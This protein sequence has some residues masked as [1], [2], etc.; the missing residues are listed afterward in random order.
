M[1][2]ENGAGAGTTGPTSSPSSGS[3]TSTGP[4]GGGASF[5]VAAF[6]GADPAE[7]AMS[8]QSQP[9]PGSET[10]DGGAETD[11]EGATESDAGA[12]DEAGDEGEGEEVATE[13]EGEEGDEESADDWL[14]SEQEKEFPQEVLAKY[15]KRYGYKP[16]EVQN[17]PRLQRALKDKL[18]ADIYARQLQESVDQGPTQDDEPETGDETAAQLTP[19]QQKEKYQAFVGEIVGNL[20]DQ[21]LVNQ[22]GLDLLTSFGVDASILNDP[23]ASPEAKAEVKALVDN[24][25]KVGSTLARY[26]VDGVNTAL[27]RLLLSPNPVNGQVPIVGMLESVMPGIST[28]WE[29]SMYEMQWTR[30]SSARGRDGQ[31]LFKDLPRYGTPEFAKALEEAGAKIPNFDDIVFRDAKGNVLPLHE[32]AHRKYML[33]ARTLSGQQPNPV[34][35]RKA[36]DAGRRTQRTADQRRAGAKAMGAGKGTSRLDSRGGEQSDPLMAAIEHQ[37]TRYGG[38]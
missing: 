2:Q 15:A 3:S 19:E 29:R 27:P 32:Q 34:A 9:D 6:I 10:A 5:D 37:N 21:K 26:L 35:A 8:E 20:F 13:G 18:N 24:A 38:I 16:E 33:L 17:D 11:T 30:A 7:A 1:P 4:T 31:P 36:F 23:K 14:P 28:M 25:P 12:G 22:M